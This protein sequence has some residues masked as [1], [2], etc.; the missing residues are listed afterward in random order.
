MCIIQ[1]AGVYECTFQPGDLTGWGSEEVDS[2]ADN[3]QVQLIVQHGVRRSAGHPALP[4]GTQSLEDVGFHVP[5]GCRV[6]QLVR[7]T[8]QLCSDLR[9]RRTHTLTNL[10]QCKRVWRG[11]GVGGGDSSGWWVGS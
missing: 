3:L 10:L 8:T 7:A 5:E 1:F 6:A 2:P 11:W 4:P 9:A